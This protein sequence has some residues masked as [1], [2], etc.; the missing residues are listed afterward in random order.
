[1]DL[2]SKKELIRAAKCPHLSVRKAYY[3][4]IDF[5]GYICV[6]CGER[7]EKIPSNERPPLRK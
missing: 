4:G 5:E 3:L 6:S 7:F 1:M 2:F